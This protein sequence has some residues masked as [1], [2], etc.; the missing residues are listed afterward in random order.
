MAQQPQSSFPS[1]LHVDMDAFFAAIEQRDDPRLR[2][3]PVIVGA[4]PNAR[5][6]VATCSYEARQYG[7]HSAMPSS[8]AYR[9]CPHAVF[10]RPRPD[11]YAFVSKQIVNILYRFSPFLER[12]SVDEAIL[13]ITGSAHL[14]G[15]PLG[16]AH[17]IKNSIRE[18][19]GL[20]ASIGIAWSPL[21]AKMAS[22]FEKP[23]GLVAMPN[24]EEEL[25]HRLAHVSIRKIP[26]IGPVTFQKLERFHIA[27]IGA[28]CKTP[29]PDLSRIVG[30]RQ[31]ITLKHILKPD[32]THLNITPNDPK[33]ISNEHTF[34]VDCSDPIVLRQTLTT[35]TEKTLYRLRRKAFFAQIINLKVRWHDFTT[36]T[37]RH[38]LPHPSDADDVI[39]PQIQRLFQNIR[40]HAPVRL[41]GVGLSKLSPAPNHPRFHPDLFPDLFP[42]AT[43]TE[44]NAQTP[45]L[46]DVLDEIRTRFGFHAIHYGC[47]PE[48][49]KGRD[50]H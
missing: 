19:L 31:A 15:G 13:D 29:L 23:D 45:D 47:F 8:E 35:L 22:D 18:E 12:V 28:L 14:Y 42:S 43:S 24:H 49:N 32:T 50:G 37:R 46:E 16:I 36:I 41:L 1:Y 17:R 39:I 20:T 25:Q 33:Q 6:V 4:L 21:L 26:G 11:Y 34:A 38:K 2:G 3:R 9:L 40:I 48:R 7:V 10:L 30:A 27:T 5:G 44:Q